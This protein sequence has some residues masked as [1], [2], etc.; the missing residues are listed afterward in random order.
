MRPVCPDNSLRVYGSRVDRDRVVISTLILSSGLPDAE[1]DRLVAKVGESQPPAETTAS[2]ERGRGLGF[3]EG[4]RQDRPL[5]RAQ[6]KLME[7]E[8]A[9]Q[10]KCDQWFGERT[11]L[12]SE[13]EAVQDYE[14]R[15]SDR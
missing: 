8:I 9:R 13:R 15:H 4:V 11:P 10:A 6:R 2:R 5:S 14:F 12:R 1:K 7:R 3:A